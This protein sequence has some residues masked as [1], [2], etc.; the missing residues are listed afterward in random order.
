MLP[1]FAVP[2]TVS[3]E[4]LYRLQQL[5]WPG[6]VPG[7]VGAVLEIKEREREHY[8]TN[9]KSAHGLA[10]SHLNPSS[11]PASPLQGHFSSAGSQMSPSHH[12]L[13]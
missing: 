4:F 13:Q 12:H 10:G 5:T 3:G 7:P 9:T 8:E 11:G 2:R 1:E 6:A